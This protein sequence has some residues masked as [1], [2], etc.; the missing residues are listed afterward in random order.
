[1][2]IYNTG[3]ASIEEAWGSITEKKKKKK[4]QD[5]ICDLYEMKGSAN[6]YS[7][8]DLMNYAYDKSRSQRPVNNKPE[9]KSIVIPPPK[10]DGDSPLPNSLFEQ[11]FDIRHSGSFEAEDPTDY[12]VRACS[13]PKS[14]KV[15][16]EYEYDMPSHRQTQQ[17]VV[18]RPTYQDKHTEPEYIY[19]Q[20]AQESRKKNIRPQYIDESESEHDVEDE[21]PIYI[22]KHKVRQERKPREIYYEEDAEDEYQYRR[23]IKEKP[24]LFYLDIILYI[25]SGIILIFLL[26][27]F[28][29]I[30]VNMQMV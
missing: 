15:T 25:L 21:E 4:Q 1:M 26:E 27:Q 3:Y 6:A 9:V 7:D 18:Y 22:K 24:K 2:T 16:D 17:E 19:R 14:K 5:P 10:E 13:A 11:Q 8:T 29:R 28:V 20:T 30:G 23:P 12:M